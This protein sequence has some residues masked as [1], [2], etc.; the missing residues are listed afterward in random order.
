MLSMVAEVAICS[1]RKVRING[2]LKQ[3]FYTLFE[4]AKPPSFKVSFGRHRRYG[5]PH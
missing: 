4:D 5:H 1:R 3:A 2:A